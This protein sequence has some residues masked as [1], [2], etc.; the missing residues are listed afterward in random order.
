[1]ICAKRVS[2]TAQ[3]NRRARFLRRAA[4]AV[5]MAVVS[6]LLFTMLFGIIEYGW[7][8]TVRQTLTTAAREGARVAALP[9]ST[10]D[11]IRERVTEVLAPMNLSGVGR[12]ALTRATQDDPT[13]NVRVWLNYGDV[14]LVGHFFGSTDFN[15]EA[16]CSMR[17]EGVD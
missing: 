11:Q 16:S 1:M 14:T 6:P 4:A 13:E 9:G 15:L 2:E 10:D 12:T 8:F 17:K 3:R 7:V 5:E